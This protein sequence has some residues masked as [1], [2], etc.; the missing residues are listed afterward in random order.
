MQFNIL[1]LDDEKLICKSMKRLLESDENVVHTA[2]SFEVARTIF[3][4]HDIDLV[5]L[6]Y[7]LGD[8]DGITVLKEIKQIYP[9][10][11][12][13]MLT[14]YATIHL[15]VEAMKLGAFDFV[16]KDEST[17]ITRYAVQRGLDHQRLRKEVENLRIQCLEK[18]SAVEII[19][20]STEMREV[21]DL[22]KEF[23]RTDATVLITGETGTGKNLLSRYIHFNSSR[24]DRNL[25][26]LNCAAIPAELIESELF[27]YESGSFTGARKGGK[28]G[29]IEQAHKSTLVLDE[30]SE[31]SI[32][33]Q[34]KLLHVLE[35]GEFYRIGGV[36]P[37][38]NDV[39]F[40]ACSNANLP[41]MIRER[42]FRSDLFYRLNVAN[43]RIPALRE[44]RMDILPLAKNFINK[45][46]ESFKKSVN[47]MD[48]EAESFLISSTWLGN[49]RELRNY[50][51][52]GVL[53][54]KGDKL[55]LSNIRNNDPQADLLNAASG[56]P[57][58]LIKLNPQPDHNLLH[59]VQDQLVEQVLELTDKNRTSAA[60]MLGIPRTSLNNY[61]KRADTVSHDEDD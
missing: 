27:G 21:L 35:S 37:I 29:L 8:T 4:K 39:R 54:A 24:F 55:K 50:I 56:E 44:R 49:V 6:D 30:I 46:N 13:I 17:E 16:E 45:F 31:L 1:I 7:S 58:F 53:L 28:Q 10:I 15:A 9:Q 52:R 33:L 60:R 23:A 43:I 34:T 5:L 36:Q 14:A 47:F 11:V 22:S 2:T 42:K 51:E 59:E 38:K 32:D 3:H 20:V 40:I 41:Q 26:T 19:S 57:T 12:V 25:V 48:K 18:T 61:I